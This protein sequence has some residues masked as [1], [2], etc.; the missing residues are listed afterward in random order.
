MKQLV[1]VSGKGGTGKTSFTAGFAHLASLTHK[2]IIADA[3]V[4][5]A[6]L[7]LVLSPTQIE[8]H[9]FTGG[10]IAVIDQN[11]CTMCGI[12]LSVCRFDAVHFRDKYEVE[13]IACEGCGSCHYQC[14]AEAIG[15]EPQVAGNWFIS[16]TPYGLTYH[17]HLNAGQENSGKLVTLVKNMARQRALDED[18][19]YLLVD[20]PPGIGCPVIAALAGADFSLIVTEPSVSGSHDLARILE[21]SSHFRIPSLVL[22][23]KVDIN[24]KQVDVITSICEINEVPVVGRIPYDP[25]VIN[26]MV[27]GLPVTTTHSPA[28]TA[29]HQAWD[30]ISEFISQH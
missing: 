5:A 7:A 21:L 23:N 30:H 16:R 19:D 20:G 26:N 3:D 18:A 24:P 17:A 9:S 15:M 27:H 6:N 22:I 10:K 1:F 4:D 12:C 8:T 2:T 25:T 29:L 11:Q 14:P 28:T 13:P